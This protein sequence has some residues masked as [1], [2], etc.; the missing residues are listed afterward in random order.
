[1]EPISLGAAAL[2]GGT[3]LLSGLLGAKSAS[4]TNAEARRQ[5][6]ENMRFQK[7]Q[8][9]DMKRYNS[10]KNQRRMMQ[11]A[12]LNPSLMF[13]SGASPVGASSVGGVAPTAS[14]TTQ[15]FDFLPSVAGNLISA[16]PQL[17]LVNSQKELADSQTEKNQAEAAGQRTDNLYKDEYWKSTN[18]LAQSQAWL[19]DKNADIQKL[20]FQFDKESLG[21]RL[22]KQR[23][24][25]EIS[26]ADAEARLIT[27]GFLPERCREELN[28]IIISQKVAIQQGIAS[29]KSA[30]AAIMSATN[31]Q[32]AFD[33]QYGGSPE[34]RN[35]FFNATLKSLHES[36]KTQR[37]T[38]FKN[39]STRN[40]LPYNQISSQQGFDY[41]DSGN[42]SPFGSN[43][44]HHG[45]I[46]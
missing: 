33:A 21:D 13:G 32:H 38:Q 16:L 7:Y 30:M 45:G 36:I 6:E 28:Q 44:R 34:L 20:Q 26:R 14:R 42:Y 8:Y 31:Q 9:E 23:W 27:N 4:D 12:G 1:M 25:S 35:A 17:S 2:M 24:D 43:K 22:F 29:L 15:G 18:Y 19:N 10:F 40:P 41:V 5:F 39:I 3:S 37:S 11:E 46:R